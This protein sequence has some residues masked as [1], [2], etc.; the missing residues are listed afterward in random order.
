M[1]FSI[2]MSDA[3]ETSG[4]GNT[5]PPQA[6]HFNNLLTGAA[7]SEVKLALTAILTSQPGQWFRGSEMFRELRDRQGNEPGWMP[8]DRGPAGLCTHSL[9]PAGL[10]AIQQ[11]KAERKRAVPMFVANTDNPA[12]VAQGFAMSGALLEWSLDNLDVSVQLLGQTA[13]KGAYRTPELRYGILRLLTQHDIALSHP[14]ITAALDNPDFVRTD[15]AKNVTALGKYGILD[16]THFDAAQDATLEIVNP[17]YTHHVIKFADLKPETQTFYTALQQLWDAGKREIIF[18]DLASAVTALA[19]DT[20]LRVVRDYWLQGTAHAKNMPG[21]KVASRTMEIGKRSAAT[22]HPEQRAVFSDFVNRLE[23]VRRDPASWPAY[24]RTAQEIIDDPLSMA[25]LFSKAK[26]FSSQAN[27]RTAPPTTMK[28]HI[29]T[30]LQQN[31]AMNV[32][33]IHAALSERPGKVVTKESV[34]FHVRKLTETG[35]LISE[36]HRNDPTKHKKLN[37]YALPEPGNDQA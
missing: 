10:V 15:V 19:P 30:M 2:S 37:Y 7:N 23:A 33:E 3:I 32:N 28:N 18:Q 27:I 34:N 20:D 36:K 8:N 31:G 5:I 1:V 4:G 22:F 26:H 6:E 14:E 9:V 29:I 35:V 24:Q 11:V 12:I 13:K 25:T 21:L 16:V 17:E